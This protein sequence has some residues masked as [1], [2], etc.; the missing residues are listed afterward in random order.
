MIWRKQAKRLNASG[1]KSLKHRRLYNFIDQILLNYIMS[2]MS[3]KI[4]HGNS[5][6]RDRGFSLVVRL[7]QQI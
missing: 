5:C 1:C 2:D 4:I 3:I 6:L 7:I